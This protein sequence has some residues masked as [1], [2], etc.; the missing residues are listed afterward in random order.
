MLAGKVLVVEE[1]GA[2]QP[3]AVRNAVY[4]AMY[5][6]ITSAISKGLPAAGAALQMHSRLACDTHI[7]ALRCRTHGAM[8]EAQ[9]GATC[10][11]FRSSDEGS[12][13]AHHHD[14]LSARIC[15][16]SFYPLSCKHG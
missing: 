3:M 1:F 7:C 5:A 6:E 2:K 13:H 11:V 15:A 16:S 4:S 10:M 12:S 9:P 8:Q 14:A